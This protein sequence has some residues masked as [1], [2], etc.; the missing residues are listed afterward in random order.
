MPQPLGCLRFVT[1][2]FADA[3]FHTVGAVWYYVSPQQKSQWKL[4]PFLIEAP[5]LPLTP[6]PPPADEDDDQP[7]VAVH[8]TALPVTAPSSFRE[9]RAA[10]ASSTDSTTLTDSTTRGAAGISD[11]TDIG[12]AVSASASGGSE[13][14]PARSS[15]TG[16]GATASAAA[17]PPVS[18]SVAVVDL[19]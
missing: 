1:P 13:A 3:C 17:D 18:I 7:V 6:P 15:A 9:I 10:V 2:I 5:P 11:G 12:F 8:V 4:P 16:Q 14:A 19:P